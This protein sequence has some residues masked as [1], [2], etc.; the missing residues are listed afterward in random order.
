MLAGGSAMSQEELEILDA[1]FASKGCTVP[2][3]VGYGQNEMAGGVTMNENGANKRGSAGRCMAYTMLKIV[4]MNTGAPVPNNTV[5]KILERSESLF[6]GYENKPEQTKESFVTDENGDEWFDT[7]DIG[8]IDDDGFLFFV[9]RTSRTIIRL[10]V[11]ASLDKI[12]SKITMS[13]YVKEVGVIALKSVPYDTPIAFVTLNDEYVGD[14]IT[15]DAI[16]NEIQSSRNPL[17]DPEMVE[18]LYIVE[19]LPYLSS[20][21]IDYRTL[22]AKIENT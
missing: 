19:S 18:K 10:D 17:N 5:G 14:D 22:Q 9:G 6:I 20:G 8:Y 11:K 1:T 4:D 12:E 15:P 2:V 16:L 13:K 7:K 3:C 21:K